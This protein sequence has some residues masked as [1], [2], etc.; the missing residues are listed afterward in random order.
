MI[1]NDEMICDWAGLGGISPFDPALVNPASVDLR[2]SGDYRIHDGVAWMRVEH[3]EVLRL[4]PGRL[5]LLDTM[6]YLTM[7]PDAAG[8]LKLK[9]SAGRAGIEHLHAGFVEPTFSGT[10]TLEIE[11][12]LACD[13]S[14]QRGC[15]LVQLVLMSMV[16]VPKRQYS[17]VGRYNRQK[18]PT[19]SK[20]W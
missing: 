4:V 20:G 9:S 3:T 17:E 19:L 15:R 8:D 6:E 10:L 7:P 5:Y 12:R 11:N 1:W 14:I 13:I 2:W 18:G 16:H